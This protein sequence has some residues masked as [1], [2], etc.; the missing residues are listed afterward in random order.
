MCTGAD[1]SGTCNY[2]VYAL[3]QCHNVSE[4]LLM[5]TVTFAPDGEEFYC[6]P[7]G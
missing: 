6:N 1:A 3:D 7:Y 5:N 2:T 4:P